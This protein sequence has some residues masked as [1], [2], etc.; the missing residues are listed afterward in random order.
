MKT[1][2]TSWLEI[3]KS[4][5][6]H[7]FKQLKQNLS[8]KTK[9]LCVVKGNAYGHDLKNVVE[10]LNKLNPGF[11]G[12][13][14]IQDALIIRKSNKKVPILVMCPSEINFIPLAITHNL[15]LSVSSNEVLA[16][17]IKK[18]LSKPLK[19]HLCIETGLG[20][21]GVPFEELSRTLALIHNK[22]N[23]VI[24]G[25]Y[26]HFSGAES[27]QFDM[28]TR[29]QITKLL[30]WE[31]AI[32]NLGIKPITHASGTAGSFLGKQFQ[33]DMCR[34]GLGLY[35][36]WP[37]DETKN[38]AKKILKPAL[39][40]KTKVADIKEL[41]KNHGIGYDVSFITD[42]PTKVAVVPVGYYD[43]IPR[44]AT[45]KAWMLVQGK[46]VPL[47]GKVM[48]NMCV[49]EVSNLDVKIGDEVV[50]IGT[51]GK[52][53]VTT[54]EWAEWS[55]TINYEIVTKINPLLPR[56]LVK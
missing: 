38:L 37:S 41:P 45:N 29:V 24:E 22:K 21:D 32:Q 27:R 43:G 5:L 9:T 26:T 19:I 7:N 13:F 16:Q 8:P 48:M 6:L 14:D 51:Q 4:A 18:K 47:R 49:L 17:I 36:L 1:F 25:L 12:V 28:L 52:S 10:I 15:S 31:S 3:S 30:E 11:Y 56:K 33:L 53:R 42:K 46:K 23:I 50:V 2:S 39:S 34:I 35:G 44:A 55:G 40:W 20:R 54:E